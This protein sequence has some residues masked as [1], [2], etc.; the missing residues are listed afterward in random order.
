M[1]TIIPFDALQKRLGH[2]IDHDDD[3]D[4]GEAADGAGSPVLD[5]TPAPG[6][7]RVPA[8]RFDLRDL[9][10]QLSRQEPQVNELALEASFC[11]VAHKVN[12]SDLPIEVALELA[13]LAVMTYDR[14]RRDPTLG[15]DR[16]F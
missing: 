16:P 10:E 1:G 6:S 9:A 8:C 14:A 4:L 12:H 5:E 3:L 15:W 7:D 13:V 2:P 11:A